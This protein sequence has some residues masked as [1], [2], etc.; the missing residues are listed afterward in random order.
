MRGKTET[1]RLTVEV[2]TPVHIGSGRELEYERDYIEQRGQVLVVDRN[3]TL[4][5]IAAGDETLE[6]LQQAEPKLSSLVNIAGAD[7]GY[8]LP[9]LFNVYET[10]QNIGAC[11]KGAMLAPYMPGSSIKGA[12]RTALLAEWLRTNPN[13]AKTKLPSES[14]LNKPNGKKAAT[15]VVKYVFG[16]SPNKDLLRALHAGDANFRTENLRLADIRW[17]NI[18]ETNNQPVA[19]WRNMSG[20]RNES[21]WKKASGV[22]IEVLAPESTATMALQWDRFLLG[23]TKRWGAPSHSSDLLPPDF[24]GLC[25]QLN[26]HARYILEREIEFFQ[27]YQQ[28]EV[29]EQCNNLLAEIQKTDDAAYLR[30]AWGSG[31]RGMTGDWQDPETL[32]KMRI[33]YRLGKS[34]SEI[35]PKTRRLAVKRLPCLPLGWVRLSPCAGRP[36]DNPPHAPPNPW[37]DQE[38]AAI[39]KKH[40]IRADEALRGQALAK[41]WQSLED[42]SLKQGALEYIRRRWQEQAGNWWENPPGKAAKKALQI[43]RGENR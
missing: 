36:P 30:L 19:K 16:D 20:K 8:P 42:E 17:L 26:R 18:T 38:I 24:A 12:I 15:T 3:R 9:P 31:W 11:I 6:S 29:A 25:V 39:Q 41:S 37:V 40:N 33:L 43:Y 14:S 23:D 28:A 32:G 21:D 34:G 7:Y 2:L 5:A 1:I 27:R 22:Y 10:P 4:D 35:F 13:E